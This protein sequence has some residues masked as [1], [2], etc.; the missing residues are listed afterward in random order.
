MPSIVDAVLPP[1]SLLKAKQTSADK[2]E[3]GR[4]KLANLKYTNIYSYI[5]L[6]LVGFLIL[7]HLLLLT[8][9]YLAR[10]RQRTENVTEKGTE[11]A[12]SIIYGK[13]PVLLRLSDR[14]DGSLLKPVDA[15]GMP[16]DWTYLRLLLVTLICAINIAFCLVISVQLITPNSPGS[17]LPRAFSRRCGRMA[18]A[19]YPW[20]F[21][22]A[23]RNNIISTLTGVP[24]QEVRFY[25][26]L[27]GGI[28]FIE[29]F[30]HTFAYI[31]HFSIYQGMD[32]LAKDYTE[33]YFKMGIVAIVFMF[34]NCFLG[35]KWIRRRSYEIFLALHVIGAALILAGSWYHRPIIQNWV[36]AATAIWVFERLTRLVL[37]FA[38]LV[39]SRFIVRRPVVRAQA[40]VS[41]GAIKLSVPYP[42]GEWQPG[43]HAYISFWGLD[44]LCRP[45]L[46]GQSHPFSISNTPSA[47]SLEERELKFVLRI[48]KGITRELAKMIE[49]KCAAKGNGDAT[50]DCLVSIEGPHGWAPRAEEFDSVLLIAGGSGI[51]HPSSI[52]ADV[53][54]QAAAG[55]AVTSRIKLCW[56]LQ[57][58]DQ[59]AWIDDTLSLAQAD[60]EK[61]NLPLSLSLYI[62]RSASPSTS[63]SGSSTP[64]STDSQSLDEKESDLCGGGEEVDVAP[65]VKAKRFAGRPDV[66]QEIERAVAD[67][68]GRTLI[69]AC[70]P[71]ALADEVRRVSS[72]YAG[73]SVEVQIAKFEC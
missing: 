36:Y 5:G 53:C 73:S 27:L 37:H 58:L 46:Y 71:A 4:Q 49:K 29:T 6:G 57:H 25:H 12:G 64:T 60:A 35:L 62:T 33:L 15:W 23:G 70:G 43:Q 65:G 50:A 41:N 66:A 39:N 32:A 24:Y 44:L 68:P 3:K 26:I 16:G 18:V 69:V 28:A 8:Q 11:G 52:L 9:H 21:M 47:S 10:R 40:T 13:K 31:A 72:R 2:L 56:A 42:H 14:L 38:S 17:S 1:P 19:N 54:R 45:H 55:T 48:H 51:T 30:I 22:F 20:L 67:S 7:R 63:S 61:A 59:T 34:T